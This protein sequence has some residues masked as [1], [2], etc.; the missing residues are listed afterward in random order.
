MPRIRLVVASLLGLAVLT[1]GTASAQTDPAPLTALEI[2]VACA[3]PPTFAGPPDHAPRVIGAQTATTRGLFGPHDLLVLDG[4][5]AAGLQLDQ[6][7]FVRRQNRFAL[8]AGQYGQ[9][10]RTS[11][12]IRVVAV[13]AS[14]AIAAVEHICGAIFK[15]D[16]LE[17]FVAP[18]VPAGADR[19]ETPGEPDFTSLARVVAGNENRQTAG[20]G[21]FMLIDRGSDQGVAL[22]ARFAVYRDVGVAGMP[23]AAIGEAIVVSTGRAVALTRI[24]RAIDAV[25]S[26]DYVALRK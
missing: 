22:G 2:G 17:P 19:D 1:A 4:G 20:A 25:R 6:R 15:D 10:A 12:W 16:Y 8:A 9:G 13:N 7:F 14:T 3:P 26:G 18:E 5:T 21:D 23:L 24:T 11:A